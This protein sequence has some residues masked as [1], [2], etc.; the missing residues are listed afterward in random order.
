MPDLCVFVA[1]ITSTTTE[2]SLELS[3]ETH[4]PRTRQC[5]EQRQSQAAARG[6]THSHSTPNIDHTEINVPTITAILISITLQS[7]HTADPTAVLE[8]PLPDRPPGTLTSSLGQRL[9]I[10]AAAVG[11]VSVTSRLQRRR[12][13]RHMRTVRRQK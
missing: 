9:N 11:S 13:V 6:G 8:P 4:I 7:T 2:K 3:A 1:T 5:H 10:A 12:V